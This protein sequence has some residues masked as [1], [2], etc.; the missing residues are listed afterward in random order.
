MAIQLVLGM[1]ISFPK[2]GSALNNYLSPKLSTLVNE[3][4][5][6]KNVYIPLAVG[7]GFALFSTAFAVALFMLDYKTDVKEV[8]VYQKSIKNSKNSS[9]NSYVI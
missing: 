7:L 9:N 5:T 4:G 8:A 1:S 6:Y 3:H 2:L